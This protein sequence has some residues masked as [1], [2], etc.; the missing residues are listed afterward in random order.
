MT[1]SYI[2][3]LKT[4]SDEFVV[5]KSRFIGYACPCTTEEEAVQFIQTIREKHRDAKHHCYTYTVGLNRGIIRYSDD[6]EPGGTAGMPMTDILKNE[7]IVN[8]CVVVVRYFGGVL[9]GTGGL[10]R[11]YSQGCKIAIE[12]AGIVRMELSVSLRCR[13]PY[14]FW[15]AVQ[16]AAQKSEFRI[17][18][19]DYSDAVEFEFETRIKDYENVVAALNNIT[20]GKASY[21]EPEEKYIGWAL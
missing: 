15:N 16:Y 2:T 8:C 7:D 5:Q 11:A 20:E 3:V 19:A 21:S 13:I 9:L 10:V 6:G 12:A 17:V 14:G 4:A 18:A 1:E